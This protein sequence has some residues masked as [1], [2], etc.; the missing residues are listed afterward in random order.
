MQTRVKILRNRLSH[1]ALCVKAKGV[2]FSP[3]AFTLRAAVAR[4]ILRRRFCCAANCP[5]RLSR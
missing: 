2:G 3:L 5:P 4:D 1:S